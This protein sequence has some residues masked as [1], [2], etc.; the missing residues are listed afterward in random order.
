MNW[1]TAFRSFYYENA[2]VSEDIRLVAASTALLVIDIQK[3]F[4]EVPE[5]QTEAHRWQPFF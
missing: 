2:E 5:D 4:L 1:K 3:T